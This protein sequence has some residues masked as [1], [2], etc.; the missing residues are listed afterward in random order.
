[1]INNGKKIVQRVIRLIFRK[2]TGQISMRT[3]IGRWIYLL[4]SLDGIESILEIGTWNGAGSS[5]LIACGVA[6]NSLK[7]SSCKAYGLEINRE[8]SKIATKNLRKF[9][10]FSVIHGRIIEV[11][12]LDDSG[13]TGDEKNWLN[14]DI[15]RLKSCRNVISSLPLH[16]DL[17]ILDGGEFSTYA[18]FKILEDRISRYLILDDT[19]TRKCRRIMEE[20]KVSKKFEIIFQSNERN[21]TAVLLKK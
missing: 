21:G 17:V 13:L 12:H 10:F 14:E 6:S 7:K 4:S 16:F 18:E 2:Q 1:V 8:L 9:S 20:I 3:E 19:S 11:G 15:E 5:K